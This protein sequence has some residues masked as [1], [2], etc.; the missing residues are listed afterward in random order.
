MDIKGA[1]KKH[2]YSQ[3]DVA[4]ALGITRSAFNKTV[5]NENTSINKR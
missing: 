5:H 1:I 2:G 4:N 3:V